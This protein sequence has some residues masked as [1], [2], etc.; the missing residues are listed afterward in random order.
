[1]ETVVRLMRRAM[2]EGVFPGAVLLGAL[3]GEIRFLEAFG[4]ARLSPPRPVTRDTVFDLASLTKPLATA[5]SCMALASAGRFDPDRALGSVLPDFAGTPRETVTLAQVLG[6]TAGFPDWRPWFEELLPLPPG[7][8]PARLHR[9]LVQEPLAYAP[10]ERTVYSDPGYLALQWVLTHGLNKDL[11]A[12]AREWVF[13]PLGIRDLTFLPPAFPVPATTETDPET[14]RFLEGRVHDDNARALGGV[15]GHA[16]LFGTARG[17]F[18]LVSALLSAFAGETVPGFSPAVVR[19]FLTR[20]PGPGGFVLG[21]D[22]PTPPSSS[23]TRFPPGSVG[24]LGFTGTSFWANPSTGAVIVLLTN[25]VHPTRE[26]QAIRTFRPVI[27]DAL[28]KA[29]GG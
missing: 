11:S 6:H 15:A 2:E 18:D 21:F 10:G 12:I 7:E 16:G 27:H 19:E 3:A 5:A 14:G 22:T 24:H 28:M 26:N 23:G 4:L 20:R 13:T 1:M 17:V 29:M 9:L 8:R 25:R